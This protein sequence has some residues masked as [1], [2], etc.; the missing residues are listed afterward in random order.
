[1]RQGAN[2][3]AQPA[4]NADF[5]PGQI[6]FL[7]ELIDQRCQQAMVSLKRQLDKEIMRDKA[8]LEAKI[9]KIAEMPSANAPS[10]QIVSVTSQQL[11]LQ[12]ANV[13]KETQQL[14]TAAM[15]KAAQVSYDRVMH[16]VKPILASTVQMVQYQAQDGHEIVD[17]YRREVYKQATG[18]DDNVKMLTSGKSERQITDQLHK[19]F[20]ESD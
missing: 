15:A 11:A 16:E 2:S 13:R 17:N 18:S 20:D 10:G 7:T 12:V 5:T 1:M 8:D 14:V 9:D 3:K 19:F 4:A 6:K